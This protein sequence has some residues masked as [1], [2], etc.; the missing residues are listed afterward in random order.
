MSVRVAPT[1]AVVLI[2]S[3]SGCLSVVTGDIVEEADPAA[4]TAEGLASTD[5][6]ELNRTAAV[7]RPPL[8]LVG[9]LVGFR[10][11]VAGYATLTPSGGENAAVSGDQRPE[12]DVA[13]TSL[14]LLVSTSAV[15]RGPV[16]LNPIVYAADPALLERTGVLVDV[17]EP[18]L[19]GE[20]VDLTVE[21]SD[22]VTMLGSETT[23]T[24]LS[25][26]VVGQG[27]E[28]ASVSVAVTR[29]VHE[30]DVVVMVGITPADEDAAADL[31]TLA[32][33]VVH[34]PDARR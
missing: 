33:H 22:P 27:G 31:R 6:V 12:L 14:V 29:V 1:V 7:L 32:P 2:L 3:L 30:G 19:P 20:L 17:A 21:G 5:Y 24:R 34:G 25:G 15:E 28:S 13:N 10:A 8:P 9:E 11:W 23:V 4:I 18:F 26:R 16:A